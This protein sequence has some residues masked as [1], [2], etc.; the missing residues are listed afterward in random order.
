MDSRLREDIIKVF[1]RHD[2][3]YVFL[4]DQIPHKKL[5]NAKESYGQ[6]IGVD[7]EVIL[8]YD[9]TTFGGAK[10]GFIL[11]NRAM[12]G[13]HLKENPQVVALKDITELKYRKGLPPKIIANTPSDVKLKFDIA[14]GAIEG[15]EVFEVVEAIFNLLQDNGDFNNDFESSDSFKDFNE[16]DSSADFGDYDNHGVGNSL[17]FNESGNLFTSQS[18]KIK[19]LKI[20]YYIVFFTFLIISF[21]IGMQPID[22]HPRNLFG[23]T[24]TQM[25]MGNMEPTIPLESFVITRDVDT[26][27]LEVG[28]VIMYRRADRVDR[29]TLER[30]S[31][32]FVNITDMDI[33]IDDEI[34]DRELNRSNEMDNGVEI[35]VMSVDNIISVKR[36]VE[37]NDTPSLSFRVEGDNH[38]WSD[39]EIIYDEDIIGEVI[40]TNLFLGETFI[41][42]QDE[43]SWI[44]LILGIIVLAVVVEFVAAGA[45]FFNRKRKNKDGNFIS[46]M[47]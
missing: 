30:D 11:T 28:D 10:E 26:Y 27:L 36:I 21:L 47:M 35:Y 1:N 22:A 46:N 3:M 19:G 25:A 41:I 8:L 7:E 31:D 14:M 38:E 29:V 16:L 13:K 18:K 24:V 43:F 32:M 20:S 37:I 5:R 42:N 44:E 23:Y 9:D 4:M 6:S 34:G 15:N 2:L 12:Y 40:F 17:I 33:E 45:E 39:M